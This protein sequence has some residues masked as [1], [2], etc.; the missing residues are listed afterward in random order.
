M[1]LR[2]AGN[3][4]FTSE[5][6]LAAAQTELQILE[7]KE[8]KKTVVDDAAFKM[9]LA[10]RE[11]GF[12]EAAVD[13]Q[14]SEQQGEYNVL[15]SVFEGRRVLVQTVHLQGTDSFDA[16]YLFGLDQRLKAQ[17]DQHEPFAYVA[18]QLKTFS[19]TLADFYKAEGFLD[20]SIDQS[21]LIL[22]PTVEQPV[23]IAIIVTEGE[24]YR[25][26]D[27]IFSVDSDPGQKSELQEISGQFAGVAYNP[28]LKLLLRSKIQEYYQNKGY[29]DVDIAVD[30]IKRPEQAVMDLEV[31]I[32]KGEKVTIQ[33][34]IIQGNERTSETFIR[35]RI[36]LISGQLYTLRAERESFS[37]LY[38]TGLFSK[39]GFKLESF[40]GPGQKRL[41]VD[42]EEKLPKEF[43]VEPGWGSYELLR[44]A[45]GYTD[46]NLFGT[47]RSFRLESSVS[48][49]SRQILA[50]FTDHY[51]MDT[52]IWA[53]VPIHY[54]YRQEPD[55]TISENGFGIFFSEK[56]RNK[57][58]LSGSYSYSTKKI[59][60]ID[61]T[62]DQIYSDSN[63][64]NA[65]LTFSVSRDTRDDF[66]WPQSGY[67]GTVSLEYADAL[68]GG[69]LSY[70]RLTAG[71]RE[72]IKIRD[73]LVFAMRYNMGF[74][75]PGPG[76]TSIPL[77]ERFFN[78]GENSVRSFR[79]SRLGLQD[80]T[81]AALGGTAFNTISLELRR[82][83]TTNL[84]GS[85]FIDAGNIAPNRTMTN[86]T[87]PLA[88]DRQEL[89]DATW[90]DF[91]SD[92]RYGVGFG[93]QYLLPIGPAR[94]DIGFN[95]DRRPETESEYAMHLS[96]G[97]A[98]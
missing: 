43:F 60:D 5:D 30:T 16:Q 18:Q 97:M 62:L 96:V 54:R 73:Q 24:K 98:F 42:V 75:L 17:I 83:F 39:V 10:Y 81:G 68:I 59:T 94:F 1:K 79:E 53:D 67:L 27:V 50:G 89:I 33:K 36:R 41:I 28:R 80:S 61:T 63:Y 87:S 6:L 93:I 84:A 3:S 78:G 11:A 37:S 22:D 66:F 69:D 85:L 71:V 34:I 15:F 82:T 56:F 25:I 95:P 65:A 55:Y 91:F 2:F 12:P 72:F 45:A 7:S 21:E 90:K 57:A 64:N 14:I 29:A 40:G 4:F 35:K 23:S 58:R 74:I 52:K 92:F 8:R 70:I 76:Q 44:M 46:K 19:R 88:A 51:F 48:T 86:G 9:E 26:G 38:Q 20:V 32:Q 77:D 47:G 31:V 49:K 13:Y